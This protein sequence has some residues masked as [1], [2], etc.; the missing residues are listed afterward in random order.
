MN[1]KKQNKTIEN[2]LKQ[3]K[4]FHKNLNSIK[5]TKSK[6]IERIK[7][8]YFS[9]IIEIKFSEKIKRIIIEKFFERKK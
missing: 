7:K 2:F 3:N 9:L 4:M 5:M 8:T 6:D 1:E